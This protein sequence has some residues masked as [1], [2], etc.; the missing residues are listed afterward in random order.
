ME[1]IRSIPFFLLWCGEWM[2]IGFLQSLQESADV[3][4]S[5]FGKFSVREKQQRRG[6]NPQTG[7]SMALPPRRVVTF[8]YSAVLKEMINQFGLIRQ[9]S[10]LWLQ[11]EKWTWQEPCCLARLEQQKEVTSHVHVGTVP[12]LWA[13]GYSLHIHSLQV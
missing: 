11:K 10:T 8:H 6:R 12:C 1:M 5:G 13:E 9:M 7:E 3:L 4:I 2:M